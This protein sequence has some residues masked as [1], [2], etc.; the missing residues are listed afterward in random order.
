MSRVGRLRQTA[1]VLSDFDRLLVNAM[2]GG[3]PLSSTPFDDLAGKLGCTAEDVM[4]GVESLLERGVITRFGPLFNIEHLGGTFSLC[5]L[6]VPEER[7]EEVTELVNA[8]PEVAHNY[9]R[10]HH[11]NMWFVL[12]AETRRELEATFDDIVARS[13]CPG[14][15]LPKE[16]EFYV[17]LRLTA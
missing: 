10:E 5:A 7:F 13:G 3:F 14:L 17:G 16:E 9:Q 6:H 15:N 4:A 11:W 1:Q 8:C 12:A 2:Q